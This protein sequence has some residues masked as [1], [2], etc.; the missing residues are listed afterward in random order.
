MPGTEL[1]FAIVGNE[2]PMEWEM[3][4]TCKHIN[5]LQFHLTCSSHYHVIEQRNGDSSTY[6]ANL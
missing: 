2:K 1:R 4:F 3:D 5:Y 6:Y